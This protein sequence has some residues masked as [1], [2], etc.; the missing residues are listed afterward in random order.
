LVMRTFRIVASVLVALSLAKLAV[1]DAI[2]VDK[3]PTDAVCCLDGFPNGPFVI[4]GSFVFGGPT[5]TL[6]RIVGVYMQRNGDGINPD[7]SPS[8]GTGTAFRFEVF[9][10]N[11]N[12]LVF[13]STPDPP[14]TGDLSDFPG[15]DFLPSETLSLSLVTALLDVPVP[16]TNGSR[17]WIAASTLPFSTH[18]SYQVGVLDGTGAFALST[19]PSAMTFLSASDVGL[20]PLT[21]LAIYA[22]G[23]MPGEPVP[24]PATLT[25]LGTA[26]L[27]LTSQRV[28]RRR[29]T[30]NG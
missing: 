2:I 23:T 7:G 22:S 16:L 15:A 20:D 3:M 6:M 11:M 24:E 5:G 1:A 25:L 27:A 12:H 17:Y 28:A 14:G 10:D 8:P 4:A 9:D 18:G 26:I 29:F 30:L 19:D 21:D 13:A